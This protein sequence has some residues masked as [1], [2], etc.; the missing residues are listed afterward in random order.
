M[1]KLTLI[2]LGILCS[3]LFVTNVNAA[4][5]L[6]FDKKCTYYQNVKFDN[7]MIVNY[8]LLL[9]YTIKNNQ[10]LKF[11]TDL[12]YT[13]PD[14]AKAKDKVPSIDSSSKDYYLNKEECPEYVYGVA[15][16]EEWIT[17]EG[18]DYRFHTGYYPLKFFD[19]A[20]STNP[21]SNFAVDSVRGQGCALVEF[22]NPQKVTKEQV[23]EAIENAGGSLGENVSMDDVICPFCIETYQTWRFL[24]Y[25]L[26]ILKIIVPIAIIIMGSIDLGKAVV[27]NDSDQ[28]KKSTSL[29]IKRIIA[30]IIIFFI[31]TIV[32]IV[33]NLIGNYGNVSRDYTDCFNCLLDPY[34]GECQYM[35]NKKNTCVDEYLYSTIK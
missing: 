23:E 24:G 5:E 11:E 9:T 25:L 21:Y 1:K 6:T 4:S 32:N 2:I 29:F 13:R 8:E 31:P 17:L 27:A 3:F 19:T 34:G 26:F 15:C 14:T 30:G 20:Q 33:F 10:T 7:D 35:E 28:M 12:Y 22:S 18:P 16:R